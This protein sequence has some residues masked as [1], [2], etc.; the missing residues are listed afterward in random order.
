MR[1]S[2][3]ARP[4]WRTD[5]AKHWRGCSAIGSISSC[6][7]TARRGG[8]TREARR[9]GAALAPGPPPPPPPT[10]CFAGG[11][12]QWAQDALICIAEGRL[13]AETDRRQFTPERR[14]KTRAEMVEL[15]ADLPEAVASTVEIARRCAFRPQVQA[16]I[17]PRF[18]IGAAGATV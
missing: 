17:L 11:G 9:A 2:P 1:P 14:F 6:S 5:G 4:A 10:P 12:G 8:G 13:V 16:P 15:F 18:S 7:A 3:P